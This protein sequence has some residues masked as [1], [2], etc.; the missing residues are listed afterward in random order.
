[1]DEG[2]VHKRRRLIRDQQHFDGFYRWRGLVAHT[3]KGTFSKEDLS[4][5]LCGETYARL[6]SLP[7][8]PQIS[9]AE[10]FEGLLVLAI[11]PESSMCP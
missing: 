10:L 1:M 11:R 5:Y 8:L 4:K 7:V 9:V 6:D 2:S 3:T